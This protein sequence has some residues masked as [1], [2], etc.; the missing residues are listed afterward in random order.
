M[1]GKIN[2]KIP[3]D[4]KLTKGMDETRN[5]RR[6]SLPWRKTRY[7]LQKERQTWYV[8]DRVIYVKCE[9]YDVEMIRGKT[10]G[11]SVN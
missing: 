9:N 1:T 5:T 6:K 2:A 3:Q 11:K 10:K 4:L 7:T 8:K